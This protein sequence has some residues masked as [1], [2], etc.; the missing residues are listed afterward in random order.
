M[1][2]GDAAADPVANVD[3]EIKKGTNPEPDADIAVTEPQ[4]TQQL[5]SHHNSGLSADYLS[6][7]SDSKIKENAH[8]EPDADIAVTEPQVTQQ[9]SSDHNSDPSAGLEIKERTDSEPDSSD[10]NLHVLD[11]SK[12]EE[13]LTTMVEGLDH[14]KTTGTANRSNN[15]L[16]SSADFFEIARQ[17]TKTC[18]DEQIEE[19]L[20]NTESDEEILV[21]VDQL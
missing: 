9:P 7:N 3:A 21:T 15:M 1:Q 8:P 16:S 14:V 19:P 4:V 20:S 17:A 2:N 6:A 5:S 18:F 13:F 11:D 10:M 12:L